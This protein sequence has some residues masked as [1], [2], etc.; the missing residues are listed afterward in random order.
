MEYLL[1]INPYYFVRLLSG[2]DHSLSTQSPVLTTL[3][4]P[5][6]RNFSLCLRFIQGLSTVI[7]VSSYANLH[8]L[9]I[10]YPQINVLKIVWLAIDKVQTTLDIQGLSR[11][12]LLTFL[13]LIM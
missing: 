1:F 3:Y 10:L 2:P 5:I 11:V 6:T 9:S 8:A 7:I 4:L 12:Y 13:A